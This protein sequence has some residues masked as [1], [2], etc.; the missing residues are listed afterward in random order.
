MEVPYILTNEGKSIGELQ[1]KGAELY[2]RP[3]E[4]FKPH[5]HIIE[6]FISD[7]DFKEKVK[8][9]CSL[10]IQ[11]RKSETQGYKRIVSIKEKD[12]H[13]LLG[14]HMLDAIIESLKE[15]YDGELHFKIMETNELIR[16]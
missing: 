10:V 9:I 8:N 4:R 3:Y 5:A 15:N 16:I 12:Y 7:E 11:F 14:S 6:D 13:L 2:F 1:L